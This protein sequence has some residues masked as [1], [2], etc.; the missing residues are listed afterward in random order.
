MTHYITS[1]EFA[2]EM[3]GYKKAISLNKE[4]IESFY[5]DWKNTTYSLKQYKKLMKT[6]G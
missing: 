2:C 5:D 6:R 1:F 4:Y 3:F